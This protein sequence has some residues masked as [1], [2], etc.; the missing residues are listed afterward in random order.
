[1]P[2]TYLTVVTD[3]VRMCQ[4]RFFR[5]PSQSTIEK[6]KLNHLSNIVFDKYI[7]IY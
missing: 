2:I 1:M 7:Y 5:L 6:F 3:L 4:Y